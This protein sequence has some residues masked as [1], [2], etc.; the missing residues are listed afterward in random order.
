MIISKLPDSLRFITDKL[1]LQPWKSELISNATNGPQQPAKFILDVFGKKKSK[2]FATYTLFGQALIRAKDVEKKRLEDIGQSSFDSIVRDAGVKVTKKVD[3]S[4]SKDYVDFTATISS[5]CDWMVAG[6][7]KVRS[8]TRIR[9]VPDEAT[10]LSIIEQKKYEQKEQ[11][12]AEIKHEKAQAKLKA[13]LHAVGGGVGDSSIVDQDKAALDA[14]EAAEI[15]AEATRSID[16]VQFETIETTLKRGKRKPRSN[17]KYVNQMTYATEF[18]V[19]QAWTSFEIRLW[20]GTYYVYADVEFGV[21]LNTLGALCKPLDIRD[22]PWV[23]ECLTSLPSTLNVNLHVSSNNG[24][25]NIFKPNSVEAKEKYR[26]GEEAVYLRQINNPC[27]RLDSIKVPVHKWPFA[28]ETQA[29]VSTS[30]LVRM[31]TRLRDDAAILGAHLLVNSRKFNEIYKIKELE[32]FANVEKERAEAAARE[33]KEKL[34]AEA[35]KKAALD[36]LEGGN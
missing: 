21:T 4:L 18:S 19:E 23:T 25:F 26:A 2:E 35:K 10:C 30:S 7:E 14:Q 16:V 31:L 9:I 22:A 29:E 5:S 15:E 32:Y 17:V 20:P 1:K 8:K 24:E 34:E 33:E 36:A 27:S 28:S 11:K 12:I 6:S 3:D 13:M